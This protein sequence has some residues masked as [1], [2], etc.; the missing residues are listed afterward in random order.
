MVSVASGLALSGKYVFV[1]GIISHVIFRAF[2]QIKLDV[3][4]QNLPIC[5]IGVGAGLAYGVD[6]PTHHGTEDIGALSSLPN[7]EIFN[8]SDDCSAREAV[9]FSYSLMTPCFIRMDKEQL[10]QLYPNGVDFTVGYEVHGSQNKIVVF[11]SGMTT[12]TGLKAKELLKENH[13]V[14]IM[15]IDLL[16]PK[17]FCSRK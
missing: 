11:C 6:G 8:P 7:M 3:C 13:G 5:I 16:R 10:P 9:K 12:W 17:N 1:Y 15:I 4:V 2:E 14:N